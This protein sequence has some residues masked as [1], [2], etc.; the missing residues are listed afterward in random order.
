MPETWSRKNE[1]LGRQPSGVLEVDLRDHRADRLRPH[2]GD[3]RQGQN[4]HQ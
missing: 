2:P 4:V 1:D 3:E